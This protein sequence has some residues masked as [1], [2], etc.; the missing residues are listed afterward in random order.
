LRRSSGA[1]PSFTGNQGWT[2]YMHKHSG[3]RSYQRETRVQ[4][5]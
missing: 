2:T 3:T 1:S 5:H 4:C